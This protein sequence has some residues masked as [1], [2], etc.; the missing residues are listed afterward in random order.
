M[1]PKK[2]SKVS[3]TRKNK[4]PKT[5][6]R[7]VGRKTPLVRAARASTIATQPA[8]ADVADS[9]VRF[10]ETSRVRHRTARDVLDHEGRERQKKQISEDDKVAAKNRSAPDSAESPDGRPVAQSAQELARNLVRKS[11]RSLARRSARYLAGKPARKIGHISGSHRH[12]TSDS[13]SDAAEELC[14]VSDDE[15]VVTDIEPSE[16]DSSSKSVKIKESEVKDKHSR[17]TCDRR[18]LT[19]VGSSALADP[20]SPGSRHADTAFSRFRRGMLAVTTQPE[21][22]Q[23]RPVRAPVNTGVGHRVDAS[24]SDKTPGACSLGRTADQ[25]PATV[26]QSIESFDT[27]EENKVTSDVE[28]RFDR[29]PEDEALMNNRLLKQSK[30]L[31]RRSLS[32]VS[33][34]HRAPEVE[35]SRKRDASE[36]LRKKI[37]H[38]IMMP[39]FDGES[40]LELFL[41]RFETLASYYEWQ[42]PERLFR[43]R[44]CIRGDAQYMLIDTRSISS[45]TAFI[46]ILR[47]RFRVKSHAERYRAELSRLKMGTMTLEKL[48]MKVR[49]LVS[50]AYP[51]PWGVATEIYARDAFLSALGDQE[52]RRRILMTCPPPETLEDAYDL[53]VRAV[54]VE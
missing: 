52:L 9:S 44:Q 4:S 40:D 28:D 14:P 34:R 38:S 23:S 51:G 10:S 17:A 32:A 22:R 2:T 43:L 11:A 46:D 13:D 42:E 35:T 50:K 21:V 6:T 37:D 19:A 54:A 45:I 5:S 20:C 29:V 53:A 30:D 49:S 12:T 24:A 33:H 26:W 47:Q 41:D 3:A 25:G 27:D 36:M 7:N 8:S 1:P 48:H 18:N 39:V 31:H 16:Q 15:P